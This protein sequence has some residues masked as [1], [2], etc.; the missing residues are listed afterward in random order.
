MLFAICKAQN[1]QKL[2]ATIDWEEGFR[3]NRT[4]SVFAQPYLF[5]KGAQYS[6]SSGPIPIWKK[7]I[8]LSSN[9]SVRA[10]IISR[11][12]EKFNPGFNAEQF[13]LL[14]T[15]YKVN[16]EVQKSRNE[17]FAFVSIAPVIKSGGGFERLVNAEIEIRV[18]PSITGTPRNMQPT[19]SALA[20]G[21]IY[22]IAVTESGVYK[23]S[24]SFFTEELGL[25]LANV[26]PDKIQ[27]LGTEGGALRQIVG[28]SRQ[29]DL[30]NIPVYFKGGNDGSFDG[31]DYI[32]FYS[33]GPHRVEYN[34]S[35]NR[36]ERKTNPYSF[37]KAYFIKIGS[38]DGARIQSINSLNNG[39]YAVTSF[40][41]Q[42]RF[43]EDKFNIL[44]VEDGAQGSGR[45]FFGNLY[46]QI[47]SENFNFSF[48]N[49]KSNSEI[50]CEAV[51]AGR[52]AIS[53]RFNL[54]VNGSS[55]TSSSMSGVDIGNADSKFANKG[56]ANGNINATSNEVNVTVSYPSAGD[57]TNKAWLD[58]IQL[59]AERDLRLT[60]NQ[61]VFRNVASR[62][63]TSS[64]FNLS[65]AADNITIWDLTEWDAPKIQEVTNNNNTISWSA[66]TDGVIRKYL[67][68]DENADFPAPTFKSTIPNQNLHA[69]ER[70][71]M[72]IIY[73]PTFLSQAERLA[74]HR[75]ALNGF[76]IELV[77]INDIWNEFSGGTIDPVGL[78]DFMK[79]IYDR[80]TDF[81][82]LLLF[83]DGTFDFRDVH[84]AGKN[85]VPTFETSE[86]LH[87]IYAYPADDFFGLLDEGE[88]KNDIEGL[89]D[90]AI[91]R[92][93][94]RT[95]AEATTVVNKIIHY[96]TSEKTLGDWRNRI[97]FVGDDEDG[98]AHMESSET[99]SIQTTALYPELNKVKIYLDAFQQEATSGGARF[100]LATEAFN[101][102]ILRGALITNYFGH[103]GSQ[104]W[105]QERVL[106]QQDIRS[107]KNMDNLTVFVT[108][109]C[110]FT[111]FDEPGLTTGGELALLNARGGAAA[112]FSTTRAVFAGQNENMVEALFDS[113]ITNKIPIG[114]MLRLGKN[115]SGATDE[116]SRKFGVFGDP[117]MFLQVPPL[118]VRTTSI[119]G[120]PVP[121]QP[122]GI[123]LDTL[124]ALEKVT[125]KGVVTD[126]DGNILENF[127]GRVFPTI[128]DK[129]RTASTLGQDAGSTPVQFQIRNSVVFKGQATVTNGRFEFSFIVP[130]DIDYKIGGG[131]ISY[132]AED[133]TQ[134]DARGIYEEFDVG[135]GANAT[136]DDDDP[137]LVEVFMNEEDFV[138]GGITDENPTLLAKLTDDY[139]INVAGQA[140]GHNLTAVLDGN[141]SNSF[142]LND[143][144]EAELD[145]YTKGNVRF[146]LFDIAPGKHEIQVKAWDVS[147]NSGEG[148]IEFIVAESGSLALDHVLNY[149]NPFTTNT[150]FQF[151][152]N[153]NG[154]ELDVQVQIFTVSGKLVK[155]IQERVLPEGNLVQGI[156]WDGKDDYGDQLAKGIY[157]YRVKVRN[158]ENADN[159]TS[160]TSDYEKLVILK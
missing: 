91:G 94:C 123:P 77:N 9:A 109:T 124:S 90:I 108:A 52:A 118:S 84:G 23:L 106:T 122:T 33:E 67:A 78:R 13:E 50:N 11:K 35:E 159:Q 145:D 95:L 88:G 34:E 142:L 24:A 83:G 119:N 25:N 144:Y 96:E 62:N 152:H 44:F 104:G 4:E 147:N 6:R 8:P 36:L 30:L 107:W 1:V 71:D 110:S 105:A 87:P 68:F 151:E 64:T 57:G 73:H 41:D 72:V 54:T 20:D 115:N 43:E 66:N 92:I 101:R 97:I 112:L 143:F 19:V 136:L 111:G 137:P 154:Q 16:V 140:V 37:E 89:L 128:F 85:F 3:V 130:K 53:T 10:R 121:N 155:S 26:N 32:L 12:A 127:N 2:S 113:L 69:I 76:N 133:G 157:V 18:L 139:G 148:S 39:D 42:I 49:I 158:T 17:Y 125:I 70:T 61:M 160:A 81:K 150:N 138:N 7:R 153:M 146:P 132:Y 14:D 149:P 80:D 58:Y 45:Q 56:T 117:S 46:N 114:E 55:F 74:D 5:F 15:D 126:T 22:K 131:R 79:M 141:T 60:G 86:S 59:N 75:S 47:R 27:L 63:F 135:G 99:I 82:Y 156:Q 134:T 98:N 28:E 31:G 120:R 29:A 102:N 103:G 100:P 21:D 48:P 116:N 65:D 129:L 38:E 51:M 40:N 93:P